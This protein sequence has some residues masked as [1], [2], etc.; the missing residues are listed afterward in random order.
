[1]TESLPKARSA[2]PDPAML[3]TLRAGLRRLGGSGPQPGDADIVPLNIAAID[4]ALPW[5][6]LPCAALH[7]VAA[8]GPGTA[9]IGFVATVTA[10]LAGETGT[11]LW[12]RHEH[13]LYGPGLIAFGV[14]PARLIVVR[15]RAEA[16][17][18]WA[19]EEGLRSGA[20]AAVVGETAADRP[21]AVRRLQL[22][23]ETHGVPVVLLRPAAAGVTAAGV[24]AA[25]A[26]ATSAVT[27]WRIGT[28]AAGARPGSPQPLWRVELLRCRGTACASTSWIVEWRDETGGLAVA[29]DLRHR[30]VGPAPHTRAAL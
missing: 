23:A 30:P 12:A 8:A 24:T 19:V 22:A 29:A 21:I 16:D 3:A 13:G 11:I 7:E 10:R 25:S 15:T 2:R 5:G 17:L 20:L 4:A 14:D 6:G 28:L 1:M 26:T 9:A 27:R 18:F